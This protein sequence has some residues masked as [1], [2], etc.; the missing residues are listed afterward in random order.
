MSDHR[1]PRAGT[2]TVPPHSPRNPARRRRPALTLAAVLGALWA[3]PLA[4]GSVLEDAAFLAAVDRGLERLYDFQLAAAREEL[5]AAAARYPG[6]PVGPF[7]ESL[8]GWWL[9]LADP[10]DEAA[11]RPVRAALERTLELA[12]RRLRA[13][14][15]DTDGRFFRAAALAC[16]GRLRSYD[17]EWIAAAWDGKRAID[18]VRELRAEQPRNQDLLFGLG[19]YDYYADVV[20]RQHA[21]FRPLAAFFARGDRRRGL[22][23]LARVEREGHFARVEAAFARLEIEYLWEEDTAAA[24]AHAKALTARFPGNPIFHLYLARIHAVRAEWAAARGVFAEILTR[25]RSGAAG[26]GPYQAEAALYFTGRADFEERLF[27]SAVAR[28]DGLEREAAAR[29]STSRW[30][31]LGALTRAMALDAMGQRAAALAA[32]RQTL[33]LPD[34]AQAHARAR[35]GIGRP[36]TAARR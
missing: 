18:L 13:A 25:A 33:R 26:Y 34:A 30:R 14:P 9:A 22:E 36:W 1:D 28:L 11:R 31:T 17:G 12:E 21:V 23:Q 15:R 4:A 19:L 6:H 5:G 29:G 3:G 24:L 35:A 7:L 2:L 10:D 27:P 32:Y 8:P 20:P 16:R